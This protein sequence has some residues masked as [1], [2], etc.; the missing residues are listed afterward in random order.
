M[1][2]NPASNLKLFM[3]VITFLLP[4]LQLSF[5]PMEI[6]LTNK[7]KNH[8]RSSVPSLQVAL[9]G[10]PCSLTSL[11]RSLIA[12]TTFSDLS[13]QITPFKEDEKKKKYSNYLWIII[14]LDLFV[15]KLPPCQITTAW[16]WSAKFACY[17]KCL[18]QP[19]LV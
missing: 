19:S 8:L 2:S 18:V 16:V 1:G 12:S 3:L 6:P 10:V 11:Y 15:C 9:V 13:L 5:L 17:I 7:T 14:S 4:L